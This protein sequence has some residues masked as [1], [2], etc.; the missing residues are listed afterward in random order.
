MKIVIELNEDDA[1]E[2][3]AWL[4]EYPELIQRFSESFRVRYSNPA[5]ADKD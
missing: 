3:L 4:S 2:I 5:K 1:Q